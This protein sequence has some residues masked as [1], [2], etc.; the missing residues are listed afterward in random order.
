MLNIVLA[1]AQSFTSGGIK[2][3]IISGTTNVSVAVQPTTYTGAANIPASVT[4]S[5]TTFAVTT[6][7]SQAFLNCTGL[8][9]VSLPSSINS[10]SPDAFAASGL[11]SINIP[12]SVTS[13]GFDAF[14][15]CV[16][17]TAITIPNSV[18]SIGESAFSAC[19]GLTSITIPSS[20]TSIGDFLFYGCNHLTSVSIPNSITTIKTG[21]FLECSNLTSFVIPNWITEIKSQAFRYCTGLTSIYIPSS[22]T[23]IED[24]TFLNCSS[25]TSLTCAIAA[26]LP[27]NANVFQ[28]VNQSLCSLI[29]PTG[30]LSAYQTASIWENFSPI[31]GSATL[32]TYP[33]IYNKTS[34]YPNPN[35]GRFTINSNN[36]IVNQVKIYSLDGK[37]IFSQKTNNVNPEINIEQISKGIY[38]GTVT[39]ENE[40]ESKCKL[41]IN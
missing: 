34:I 30:S 8:T 21:M 11:T 26:P 28:S 22:V 36:E 35:K 7:E 16:G 12:N 33:F 27:I 31:T 13:I 41:I 10:I 29:V 15:S 32:D 2:Y 38:L 25:L 1:S 24:Q 4:N 23:L 9:T 6:I 14:S 37:L 20:V 3:S 18:T 19:Q 39:S 5:G 17:L 40:R